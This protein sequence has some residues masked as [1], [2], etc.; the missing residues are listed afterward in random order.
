MNKDYSNIRREVEDYLINQFSDYM[1]SVGV[2]V[3]LGR[4]FGLLISSSEPL[5]LTQIADRLRVTKPAVSNTIK[6]GLHTKMFK[7]V[8]NQDSP[9]E[10]FY[11]M[12][13]DFLNMMLEPGTQKF[14][15]LK[16]TSENAIKIISEIDSDDDEYLKLKSRIEYIDI[17]FK[18]IQE[19]YKTFVERI[20]YRFSELKERGEE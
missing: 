8:R 12:K 1:E 11:E 5:S 3:L 16:E 13:I 4:I 19:E 14:N 20:K 9:R 15:F 6:L 18:I 10:D 7:K 17:S 2:K